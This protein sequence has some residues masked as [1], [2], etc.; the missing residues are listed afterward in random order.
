MA[1]MP[2]YFTTTR[3]SKNKTSKISETKLKQIESDLRSYNKRMRQLHCHDQ[4]M[5][6]K[7]YINYLHG[8]VKPKKREF[9]KYE[10]IKS[11]VR[12]TKEYPSL[13]TSDVIPTV[14]SKREPNQYTGTLVKGIAT[15]HKSNAVPIIDKEQAK[16]IASMRR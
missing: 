12:D 1:L 13:Q 10:P 14:C 16:E 2:A 6:L 4:Q 11:F 5:D 3:V 9:Q 15:M 7:E 8:K